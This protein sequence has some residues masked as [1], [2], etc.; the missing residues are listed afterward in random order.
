[1]EVTIAPNESKSLTLR[2]R[3]ASEA[4]DLETVSRELE[5]T[6]PAEARKLRRLKRRPLEFS[7]LS[8][9]ENA[10]YFGG[11]VAVR[12]KGEE[13]FAGNEGPVID[14][15]LAELEGIEGESPVFDEETAEMY[16]GILSCNAYL[17]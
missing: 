16:K 13:A 15:V 1:M 17:L 8:A 2:C 12:D 10:A 5:P 6:F 11:E 9:H 3:L 14:V 4:L 7:L